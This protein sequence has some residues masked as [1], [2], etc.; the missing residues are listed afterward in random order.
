MCCVFRATFAPTRAAF[1]LSVGALLD[2]YA[3]VAVAAA[4]VDFRLS[5]STSRARTPV[6]AVCF[7]CVLFSSLRRLNLAG[8]RT[9]RVADQAVTRPSASGGEFFRS[10]FFCECFSLGGGGDYVDR[11]LTISRTCAGSVHR[12][13]P[14]PLRRMMRRFNEKSDVGS[15]APSPAAV[16][17]EP[18]PTTSTT[19]F[20]AKAAAGS[21]VL[22]PFSTP[23]RPPSYAAFMGTSSSGRAAALSSADG[24]EV[25]R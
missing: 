8:D 24:G 14:P 6:F 22:S 7:G 15:S 13:K 1:C 9:S 3:K 11:P 12:R 2:N 5:R 16:A 18:A 17:A 19:T 23:S 4:A 10:L 20:T 21:V 25:R